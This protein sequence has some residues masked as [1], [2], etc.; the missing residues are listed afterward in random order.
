ME[1]CY[2]PEIER[3][4]RFMENHFWEDIGIEDVAKHLGYDPRYCNLLF[5]TCYGET[6]GEYLRMLRME[7]AKALLLS[8]TPVGRVAKS[9]SYKPRGFFHTFR[10]YFKTTPSQYVKDGKTY[11]QYV[12]R[13]DYRASEEFWGDGKNPTP[14]GLWEF[15]YYDPDTKDYSLMKWNGKRWFFYALWKVFKTD[16]YYYCRHRDRGHGMHPGVKAQAVRTFLCPH[17]GT[18]D[19]YFSVG[20][21]SVLKKGYTPCSVQLFH[22]DLLLGEPVVLSSFRPDLLTASLTVRAGDR[23]RLHLDAMEDRRGDGVKLFRQEIRYT[24]IS[25]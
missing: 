19:V 15:G 1:R 16:P 8:G 9:L 14:D 11:G 5:K 21:A 20:R 18:V 24:E 6:L 23:I 7:D 17:D 10:S 22:N 3:M 13:Y 2:Y 12:K 4:I 25:E